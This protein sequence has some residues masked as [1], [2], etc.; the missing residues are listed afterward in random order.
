MKMT[1][2][3]CSGELIQLRPDQS[4]AFFSDEL[5]QLVPGQSHIFFSDEASA[6]HPTEPSYF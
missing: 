1:S 3:L 6:P 2:I 4:E 5:I